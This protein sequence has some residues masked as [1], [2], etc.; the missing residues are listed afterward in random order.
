MSVE[1]DRYLSEHIG[2]V[3]KGWEWMEANLLPKMSDWIRANY[4]AD[5]F[6]PIDMFE[7]RELVKNHDSSKTEPDEYYFY[8]DYFY[9]SK[10]NRSSEVVNNFHRAFLMHV[11]RNPHHWQYWVLT[12]DNAGEP[13]RY[14]EMPLPYIFEM[15][16]DWWSFSWRAGDLTEIFK[17]WDEHKA[18][19]RLHKKSRRTVEKI[20]EE[21]KKILVTE[22]DESQSSDRDP[23]I[24]TEIQ[25]SDESEEED[26]PKKFGVPEIKKYPMPD[27]DHV[28]S[29][30]R[31]FNYIDPKYEKELAEA[32]LERAKE[33]GIDLDEM[34]IGD[35]NRFK[36]YIPVEHSGIKGMKWGIKNGPPYPIEDGE[37]S[38]DEQKEL[39]LKNFE[40]AKVANLESWGKDEDHNVLYIAGYSGSGKSTTALALANEGDTVVHLDA[41][42]EIDDDGGYTKLRN[43]A[44]TDYLDKHVDKWET[45]YQSNKEGDNGYP[46]RHSPEYWQKVD[47]FDKAI[48]G[49]AK[50]QYK[51]GHKVIVE[52]VQIADGW[53]APLKD[54]KDRP[55]V[56]LQ[57]GPI[58]SLKRAFERDDRGGLIEG[59]GG[60]KSA[61]EY[62]T[63]YYN[64]SKNL[65]TLAE[66]SDAKRN[67]VKK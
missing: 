62:A 50:E 4:K 55:V 44:F 19:I 29:A 45:V 7:M 64:M 54:Y 25:H 22:K 32:I 36:N 17:W 39:G 5:E 59:L 2:G 53:L 1:Y 18:H 67:E 15:I 56:I 52:G 14:I 20:L 47:E 9:L 42:T 27:A 11:H 33:Y 26:N 24:A 63:W 35:E 46:V 49:Y 8:D 51:D 57:N 3:Q 6:D 60:L 37:H 65:G 13:E 28:R 41:Y 10:D 12:S 23:E 66:M 61:K 34:D 58:K 16:C 30:I 48:Q 38:K 43:K 31:F 21:M 40:K